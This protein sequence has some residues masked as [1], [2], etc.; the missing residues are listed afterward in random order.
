MELHAAPGIAPPAVV[1]ILIKIMPF[2]WDQAKAQAVAEAPL[3]HKP[4]VGIVQ[5]LKN[6]LR[7][8]NGKV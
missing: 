6:R 4:N 7:A 1:E 8:N 2:V 3:I 5:A